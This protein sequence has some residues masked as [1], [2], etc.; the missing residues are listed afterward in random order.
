MYQRKEN[1]KPPATTVDPVL[2]DV[3]LVLVGPSM[4]AQPVRKVSPTKKNQKCAFSTAS[5]RSI[6]GTM[7]LVENVLHVIHLVKNVLDQPQTNA[8]NASGGSISKKM[9]AHVSAQLTAKS[10]TG[11]TSPENN[12]KSVIL[13]ANLVLQQ[14]ISDVKPV[15]MDSSSKTSNAY[16]KLNAMSTMEDMST[17]SS[18]ANVQMA[19][20]SATTT[21]F[22]SIA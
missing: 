3:P 4:S 17:K 2:M 9:K 8:K 1:I 10:S 5:V 13:L 19:A 20:K 18:V 22:A 21:S 12:A 14:E 6:Q 15:L 7:S 11:T 16:P